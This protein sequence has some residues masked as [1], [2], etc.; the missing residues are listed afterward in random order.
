MRQDQTAIAC[1]EKTK[2]PTARLAAFIIAY[3]RLCGKAVF[4][5][6]SWVLENNQLGDIL[7]SRLPP[8]II[9]NILRSMIGGK[10][11]SLA[12]VQ[13]GIIDTFRAIPR[14]DM[15]A[16]PYEIDI[17]FNTG[18]QLYYV[19]WL[20]EKYLSAHGQPVIHSD[21]PPTA[22]IR[23]VE[24]ASDEVGIKFISLNIINEPELVLFDER[25]RKS[26]VWYQYFPVEIGSFMGLSGRAEVVRSPNSVPRA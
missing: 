2:L 4:D 26:T 16:T 12:M 14:N 17:C 10:F 21:L 19:S 3:D 24:V 23:G 15:P 7:P 18:P 9:L 25:S 22:A 6:P 11:H 5:F 13:A 1:G 8:E 20:H